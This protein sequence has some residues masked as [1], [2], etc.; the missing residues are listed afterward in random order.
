[1][2]STSKLRYL[3]KKPLNRSGCDLLPACPEVYYVSRVDFPAR[4][5]NR[6]FYFLLCVY[7]YLK[8]HDRYFI[9]ELL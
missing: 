5:G 3:T 1:M 7:S 9:N 4:P 6:F 2:G 8:V